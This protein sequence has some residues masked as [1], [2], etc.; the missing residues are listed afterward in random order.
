MAKMKVLLTGATG[1][2]ASQLLPEFR[3]RYDLRMIDVKAEDAE[4]RPVEGVE[5]ADLLSPNPDESAHW[6]EGVE[7]VVHIGYNR[8]TGED[9]WASYEGQRLNVD[10]MQRVYQLALDSG[11]KRVVAASTNQ[12][13][14]WYEQPYY[15]GL[16]DRVDPE[17]YPRADGLYGWAKAA[18]EAL[19]FVYA[20]G[21][22]GGGRLEVVHI[23]IVC[24]RE[25][26]AAKFEGQPVERY[27]RDITGYISARDLRQLFSK[28]LDTPDIEDEHGVPFHIF[29]GVS[30]NARKFWSITNARR[31]IG[32]APEDDSEVRFADDIRRMLARA[33][34]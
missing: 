23:R 9:A 14:K 29:N 1:Y 19:G 21:G 17:D 5:V 6:F 25:I 26:E 2:I 16:L 10:M 32:Y 7:A 31:V 22:M 8:P 27:L 18:Y 20:C 13:A 33:E 12:A 3:E 15:S 34:E 4:G 30:N 24:P 11:V 28:S